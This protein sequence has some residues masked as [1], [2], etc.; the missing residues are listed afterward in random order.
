[1]IAYKKSCTDSPFFGTTCVTWCV[2]SMC[3][4]A[5]VT[6]SRPFIGTSEKILALLLYLLGI[7]TKDALVLYDL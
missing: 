3:F 6:Y 7:G 4:V 2:I 5:K 1:M